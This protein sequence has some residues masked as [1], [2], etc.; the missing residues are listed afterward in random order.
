MDYSYYSQGCTIVTLCWIKN[1]NSRFESHRHT[2]LPNKIYQIYPGSGQPLIIG[3]CIRFVCTLSFRIP[4]VY[5]KHNMGKCF[6]TNFMQ[7]CFS[8]DRF[9]I[10]RFAFL[11]QN[12]LNG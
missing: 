1:F 6:Y 12:I 3:R 9:K 8:I 4:M 5:G 2:D 10:C 11:G 7:F